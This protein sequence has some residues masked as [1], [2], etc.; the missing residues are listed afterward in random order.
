MGK[1]GSMS[2]QSWRARYGKNLQRFVELARL[3]D[4]EGKFSNDYTEKVQCHRFADR[5]NDYCAECNVGVA[6]STHTIMPTISKMVP[7]GIIIWCL[8]AR[9]PALLLAICPLVRRTAPYLTRAPNRAWNCV[10]VT[11]WIFGE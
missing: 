2:P 6:P 8:D 10:H 3:H 7:Y 9:L 11:Q 5:W 4:P 1:L